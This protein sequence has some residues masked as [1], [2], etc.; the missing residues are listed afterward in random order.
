MV[1]VIRRRIGG[2]IS[3]TV[4][5]LAVLMFVGGGLVGL[6]YSLDAID[7]ARGVDKARLDL[8]S[9]CAT[10][11]EALVKQGIPVVPANGP[12]KPGTLPGDCDGCRRVMPLRRSWRPQPVRWGQVRHRPGTRSAVTDSPSKPR[13][14]R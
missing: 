5:S 1:A 7:Q 9:A 3:G 2:L 12:G 4:T 13:R 14:V 10:T 11:A 8:L 6:S